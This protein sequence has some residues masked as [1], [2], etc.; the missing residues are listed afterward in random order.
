M[1]YMSNM[2]DLNCPQCGTTKSIV[3]T[4]I[5]D[6]CG[7]EFTNDYIKDFLEK[8]K[9]FDEKQLHLKKEL[10]KREKREKKEL[11]SK[12]KEEEHKRREL[13]EKIDPNNQS[14]YDGKCGFCGIQGLVCDVKIVD[15]MGTRYRCLCNSCV[16]KYSNSIVSK[17]NKSSP[18]HLFTKKKTKVNPERRVGKCDFCEKTSVVQEV[19]I[20]DDMGTR[21]R[22][23]CDACRASVISK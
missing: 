3:T 7:Y 2:N 18:F 13:D 4:G 5:C 1:K 12:S 19:T 14:W 16:S 9:V 17:T 22:K 20:V 21:Y 23:L 11:R 15:D 10:K 6:C 8:E